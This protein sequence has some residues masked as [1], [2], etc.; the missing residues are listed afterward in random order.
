MA[1]SKRPTPEVAHLR[2]L[3]KA[4]LRKGGPAES[5]PE[6]REG[7]RCYDWRT[8]GELLADPSVEGMEFISRSD[9]QDLLTDLAAELE[10]RAEEWMGE[11]TH[12][13]AQSRQNAGRRAA[14]R[15]AAQLLRSHTEEK[16]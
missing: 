15:E 8:L 13:H 4:G 5:D 1:A 7:V 9:L 11:P 14:L 2:R 12:S 10:A 6:T 3:Q 16:G